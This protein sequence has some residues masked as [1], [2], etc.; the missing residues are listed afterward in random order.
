MVNSTD[1]LRIALSNNLSR[2]ADTFESL[3]KRIDGP[4]PATKIEQFEESQAAIDAG[5]AIWEAV[6]RGLLNV[7]V[8]AGLVGQRVGQGRHEPDTVGEAK[9]DCANLFYEVM[10]EFLYP[11]GE[12]VFP[13]YSFMKETHDSETS[14]NTELQAQWRRHELQEQATGC[15]MLAGLVKSDTDDRFPEDKQLHELFDKLEVELDKYIN[16]FHKTGKSGSDHEPTICRLVYQIRCYY[17]GDLPGL[18]QKLW[19]ELLKATAPYGE[20]ADRADATAIDMLDWIRSKEWLRYFESMRQKSSPQIVT[21]KPG[22]VKEKSGRGRPPKKITKQ[23]SDFAKKCVEEGLNW[24]ETA[25]KY[26]QTY[27]DDKEHDL[28]GFADALRHAYEKS[29]GINKR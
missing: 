27:P 14:E 24:T 22:N 11:H 29:H 12:G 1:Y 7:P 10:C 20:D 2:A 4:E 9:T 15:R 3:A 23:R 5:A 8:I 19:D 17:N 18:L 6:N 13:H 16:Y 28:S 21:A 25:E 26:M